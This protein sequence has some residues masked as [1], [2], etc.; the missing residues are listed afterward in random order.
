MGTRDLDM[1]SFESNDVA[2]GELLLTSFSTGGGRSGTGMAM[3]LVN[4]IDGS[5]RKKFNGPQEDRPL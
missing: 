1:T 5:E 4:P 2:F 3:Y